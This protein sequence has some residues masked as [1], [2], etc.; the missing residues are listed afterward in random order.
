MSAPMTMTTKRDAEGETLR[1]DSGERT[2]VS[3]EKPRA[4]VL[5][6]PEAPNAALHFAAVLLVRTNG[7]HRRAEPDSRTAG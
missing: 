1:N 7:V 3:G 6:G 4:T 5:G 2:R